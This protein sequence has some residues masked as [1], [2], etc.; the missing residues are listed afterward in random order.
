MWALKVCG[1]CLGA[2]LDPEIE[3]ERHSSR[4]PLSA[5]APEG[6]VGRDSPLSVRGSDSSRPSTLSLARWTL[7]SF[8]I[9][10]P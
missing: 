6:G 9:R 8:F 1:A 10:D 5:W 7:L 4:R 2:I 3:I